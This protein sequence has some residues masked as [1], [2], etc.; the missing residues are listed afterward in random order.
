NR[1][2]GRPFLEV[3]YGRPDNQMATVGCGTDINKVGVADGTD[4]RTAG[5]PANKW[6]IPVIINEQL[7]NILWTHASF[8]SQIMTGEDPSNQWNR[9]S[10]ENQRIGGS[11]QDFK[12]FRQ[13][14]VRQRFVREQRLTP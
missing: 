12:H 1:L 5:N 9:I 7:A 3:V 13:M 2:P 11:I 4:I 14:L 6:L 10:L 8:R